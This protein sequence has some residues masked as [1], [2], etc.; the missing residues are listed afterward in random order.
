MSLHYVG[1]HWTPRNCVFSLKR[2]ILHYQQ[3][4]TTTTLH[5]FN[6]LFSRTTWISRY[7]ESKTSL[8]LNEVRWGFGKQWHQLDHMQTI[9]TSH[10]PL[11]TL[12]LL[13]PPVWLFLD[14]YKLDSLLGCIVIYSIW[15]GLLI[16]IKLPMTAALLAFSALTL[17]VGWQE[18]HPACKKQ[19]G[20]VLA[21]LPVWS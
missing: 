17:L 13:M 8:D 18:G 3:R 2:C 6:G 1:K 12:W 19:S 15:C 21:W 10:F 4:G 20:G 14:F 11:S 5:P 16:W 7:Q 9:C